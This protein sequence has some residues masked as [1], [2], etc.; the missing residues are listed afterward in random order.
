MAKKQLKAVGQILS[1]A[2]YEIWSPLQGSQFTL[3]SPTYTIP[4]TGSNKSGNLIRWYIYQ[5]NAGSGAF[6][7]PIGS[8]SCPAVVGSFSGNT[9]AWNNT[10]NDPI[11]GDDRYF[12]ADEYGGRN[13]PLADEFGVHLVGR[14]WSW[15]EPVPAELILHCAVRS[16]CNPAGK[17]L[18][19]PTPLFHCKDA[20]APCVWY[21]QALRWSDSDNQA[22]WLLKLADA[23]TWSLVLRR[24]SGD[25]VDYELDTKKSKQKHP[26]PIR[27]TLVAAEGEEFAS[28]KWPKT[29]TIN[30][31]E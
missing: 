14:Y 11:S 31:A 8:G 12:E 5:W 2:D 25:H 23:H 13:L 16:G 7:P 6:G 24:M 10:C 30:A 21:S 20:E 9:L 29:I 15:H 22:H 19:R 28:F 27:P 17:L 18:R 4:V 3:H 1:N 26:F